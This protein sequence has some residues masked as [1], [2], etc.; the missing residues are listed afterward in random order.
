MS[1]VPGDL[2]ADPIVDTLSVEAVVTGV[3]VDGNTEDAI[4]PA[5]IIDTPAPSSTARVTELLGGKSY[6]VSSGS[7]TAIAPNNIEEDSDDD[8]DGAED[9]AY[10]GGIK[11]RDLSG[12]EVQQFPGLKREKWWSAELLRKSVFCYLTEITGKSGDPAMLHLRQR[13]RSTRLKLFL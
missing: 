6:S 13:L 11:L 9:K 10:V 7:G 4:N 12:S 1:N 8:D 5:I 2:S 3:I